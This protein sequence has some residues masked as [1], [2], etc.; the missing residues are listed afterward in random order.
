MG[1]ANHA[2]SKGM[3]N[4]ISEEIMRLDKI[5]TICD[6]YYESYTPMREIERMI[7]VTYNDAESRPN[8]LS[9]RLKIIACHIAAN[10]FNKK[11][12]E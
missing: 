3:S 6:D 1:N 10:G 2:L 8:D 9:S 5:R 11:E 7:G 12:A 4:S